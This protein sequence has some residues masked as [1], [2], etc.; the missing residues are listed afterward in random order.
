MQPQTILNQALRI[1]EGAVFS[2]V[3]GLVDLARTY[4]Q[5][6]GELF[7]DARAR[8][9][10]RIIDPE[11]F[12]EFLTD[13]SGVEVRSFEAI[14]AYL[15]AATR[16]ESM[17]YSRN[18]KSKTIHPFHR[19]VLIQKRG[20]RPMLYRAEDL[21]SLH[22]DGRIVA[23]ENAESFLWLDETRFLEEYFVY[24]GGNAN[25][26]T[27][28]FLSEQDVLFFL[29]YDIVSM[30][31]YDQIQT[32]TKAL[33]IPEDIEILMERYGNTALYQKQ[34]YLLRPHYSD[35]AMTVISLIRRHKKVLEQEVV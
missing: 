28:A 8:E 26:L 7:L 19:T 23:I 4:Q 20:E 18:S 5:Q 31:F 13:V 2:R 12:F 6:H 11:A 30:N 29:D 14:R 16:R 17:H 3:K 10:V 1:D 25:T 32:R 33:Y 15:R 35:E 21:A 34:R 22:L 27:R 24:L 9:R